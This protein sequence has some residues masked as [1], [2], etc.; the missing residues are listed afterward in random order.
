MTRSL[1]PRLQ[2]LD[3]QFASSPL[4]QIVEAELTRQRLELWVKRDDLLHPIISGNKWRKLKYI[5]NHALLLGADTIVSMGGAYS[6]HLHALAFA[7]KALGVKT[8]G[9]IR[10][11]K[12][13]RFSPTLLDLQEWGMALRFVSRSEYRQLRAYKTHDSLPHLAPGQ[14]WLPE[15]G[16]TEFA[17]QGVAEIIDEIDQA[18]DVLVVA[19]GTGTTL[20]GLIAAAPL[21]TQ[22]LGIAALKGAEY[23]TLEVQQLLKQAHSEVCHWQ[24]LHH[25]HGG[26]FAKS[27]PALDHFMQQ[28]QTKHD[29][30]LEPVYNGKALFAIDDL[31]KKGVFKA[32]QRIIFL[33]T[34][35]LQGA[36]GNT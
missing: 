27:T 5:L 13:A 19:C 35:G 36:R 7:G 25:Y 12:P 15:G 1:H 14:Y 20:A 10:G 29:V 23:L 8:V 11:E 4:Q 16:A 21:E 6:N 26:G 17:L 24:I 18:F 3:S 9:F 22:L 28:F 31:L 33:H 2:R 34:G 32:G 30:P